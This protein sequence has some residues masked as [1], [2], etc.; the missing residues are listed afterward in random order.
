MQ[1]IS[2]N[3]F[4]VNYKK[5]EAITSIYKIGGKKCEKTSF[6]V[7]KFISKLDFGT[8]HHTSHTICQIINM[9]NFFSKTCLI[10]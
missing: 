2:N 3:F 10:F 9:D 5:K 8:T 7:W 6:Y 4:Q 1:R